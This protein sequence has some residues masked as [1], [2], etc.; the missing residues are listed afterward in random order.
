MAYRVRD[1]HWTK[2]AVGSPQNPQ[3]IYKSTKFRSDLVSNQSNMLL[4]PLYVVQLLIS[5]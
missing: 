5:V 1:N 3:V 4:I 2:I